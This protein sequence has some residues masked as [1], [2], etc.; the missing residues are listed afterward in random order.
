M[1]ARPV[2]RF[3]DQR[4]LQVPS[5]K[6][7]WA[8]ITTMIMVTITATYFIARLTFAIERQTERFDEF[9]AGTERR[10]DAIEARINK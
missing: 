1:S 3:D 5:V 6:W 9:K 2:Y 10:L 7:L 4:P 8:A